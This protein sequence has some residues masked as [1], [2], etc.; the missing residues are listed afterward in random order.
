MPAKK[1]AF[2]MWWWED[3]INNEALAIMTRKQVKAM[4]PANPS[5][6]KSVSNPTKDQEEDAEALDD[7]PFPSND[8]CT[9]PVDFERP[10][11]D[12]NNEWDSRSHLL[13]TID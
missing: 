10:I 11:P 8:Q 7:L 12:F 13:I 4:A 5:Q 9:Y 6:S 2:A 1:A 3:L